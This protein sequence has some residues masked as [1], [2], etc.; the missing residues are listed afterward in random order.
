MRSAS[1][2]SV[3]TVSCAATRASEKPASS[4][5]KRI[6]LTRIPVAIFPPKYCS[7][8]S[9]RV[10][11]FELGS[12]KALTKLVNSSRSTVEVKQMLA[13]PA[14]ES[15]S[16]KLRSAGVHS[17]GTPSRRSWEPEVPSRKPACPADFTASLS[18]CHVAS[19]W[20]AARVCPKL[21]SR[22]YLRRTLRLRTKARAL[23][24]VAFNSR[25]TGG[26]PLYHYLVY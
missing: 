11:I 12:M 16:A 23:G 21:Y 3:L 17:R 4:A 8:R 26:I 13:T 6:S 22:A 24:T 9:Q 18:S 14:P 15:R 20:S 10:L 19:N 25:G 1:A 5:T 7:S 2:P